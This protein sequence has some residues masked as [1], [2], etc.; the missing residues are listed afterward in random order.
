MESCEKTVISITYTG[1]LK[2]DSGSWDDSEHCLMRGFP[3]CV[4][5]G[6]GSPG[7]KTLCDHCFGQER[8]LVSVAASRRQAWL[9]NR[10]LKSLMG[11]V[12]SVLKDILLGFGLIKKGWHHEVFLSS[13]S[14][15]GEI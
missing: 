8:L 15:G 1:D 11:A 4:C 5:G 13:V 12:I 2:S 6:G 14:V 7:R 9:E 3:G 10:V